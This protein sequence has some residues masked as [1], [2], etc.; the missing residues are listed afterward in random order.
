MEPTS[1]MDPEAAAACTTIPFVLAPP[2]YLLTR[3]AE[4]EANRAR[5]RY[6][7]F[8]GRWVKDYDRAMLANLRKYL[9]RW[10]NARA[11][12]GRV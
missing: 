7:L 1:T 12:E 5:W 11:P 2:R 6:R 10:E 8:A 9:E 3:I 4:L